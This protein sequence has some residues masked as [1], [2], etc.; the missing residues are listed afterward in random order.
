MHNPCWSGW[1]IFL[2]ISLATLVT[3]TTQA[4]DWRDM[5]KDPQDGR[6]DTS[7]WLL[8]RRGFLPVPI[9]ITE[10]AVGYGGGVALAFLHHTESPPTAPGDKPR[11]TP[12]SVRE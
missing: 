9:V 6:L 3:S 11:L 5:F 2:A 1:R 10:P 12:L 7:R 4:D 8:E